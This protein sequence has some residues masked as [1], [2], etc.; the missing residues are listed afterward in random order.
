MADALSILAIDDNDINLTTLEGMVRVSF[1]D[2]VFFSADNG[3]DALVLAQREDPDVILLDIIMPGMDGFEVCRVLK[4]DPR[5]AKIPVIFVTAITADEDVRFRA[6]KLGAEGFL[7]KP[8]RLTELTAQI[9]QFTNKK[10]ALRRSAENYQRLIEGLPDV[11]MRFDRDCRHTYVSPRVTQVVDLAPADFMG[12]TH[13]ELGFPED[14]C[15]IWE[16]AI[17]RVY[18]DGRPLETEFSFVGKTGR[19][20]FDWRLLP[21][22]NERGEVESV[23]TIARDI[24]ESRRA[25]QSF[26]DLF[27]QMQEGFAQ[28]E[29]ICDAQGHPIDYR[30]IAVNPAFERQTG[31]VAAAIV[32]KTVLELMPQ[33]ERHWIET[34]GEVAL[35]GVPIT[36]ENYS[37]SLDRH[38]RVSAFRPAPGQ[39]ACL[40]SDITDR[41]K[42]E[43]ALRETRDYLDNLITSRPDSREPHSQCP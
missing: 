28:H 41:M 42:A 10:A 29:I 18:T 30:F 4:A 31:L 13:R 1:P 20:V 2:A 19:M 7:T 40:F 25:E 24:S 36:F 37:A 12:K 27:N 11:V 38:F 9:Q 43:A 17:H 15:D 22:R 16:S 21:E 8:V 6:V 35:T 34:Y 32:G 39:F 26:R 14:L 23:L 33:T 5:T 3:P